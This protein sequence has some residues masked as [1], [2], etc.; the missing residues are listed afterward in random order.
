MTPTAP[1]QPARPACGRNPSP[2]AIPITSA[3]ATAFAA[4]LATTWPVSTAEPR[5]G[6]DRKRST[7]GE[8]EEDVV[9][10]RGAQLDAGD[11]DAGVVELG[12]QPA[13]RGGGAV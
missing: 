8:G 2:S 12:E 4:M 6:I 5:T 13:Q 11:R 10:G 9:E 7:I 3:V 1:S